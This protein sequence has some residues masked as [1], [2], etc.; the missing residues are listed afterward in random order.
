MKEGNG[1][2]SLL[3]NLLSQKKSIR[4]NKLRVDE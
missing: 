1:S 2:E 4:T 3:S